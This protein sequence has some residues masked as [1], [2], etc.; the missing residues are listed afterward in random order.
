[1][2]NIRYIKKNRTYRIEIYKRGYIEYN[3][4]NEIIFNFEVS[5]KEISDKEYI[6]IFMY[7]DKNAPWIN[8]KYKKLYEEKMNIIIS[9]ID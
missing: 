7:N 6:E 8:D 2:K 1:M 5:D 4:F 3:Y 9:R